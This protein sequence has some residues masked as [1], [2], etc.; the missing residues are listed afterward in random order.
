MS[1]DIQNI[2][3]KISPILE[4]YKV[5]RAGVFGSY[6]RGEAH[7]DSDVDILVQFNST[8]NL[9]DIQ[10]LRDEISDALGKE[11]DIV[12]ENAVVSYFKDYIYKDLQVIYG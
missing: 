9:F 8:S 4:K 2:Q 6:A 7:K 12:S 1:Q 5:I 10:L 3:T 11:A